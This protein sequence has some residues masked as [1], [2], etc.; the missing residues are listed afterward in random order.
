MNCAIPWAPLGLTA[1]ALKRLSCQITRAK[2]STGRPLAAAFSST[3]RQM[4]S[5]VGGLFDATGW[6][7]AAGG[8]SVRGLAGDCAIACALHTAK[9]DIANQ[10]A[11]HTMLANL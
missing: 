9:I 3:A 4:S 10:R 11:Q 5:A 8:W 7:C 1:C 2:N 6:P